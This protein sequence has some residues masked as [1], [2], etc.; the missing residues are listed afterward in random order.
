LIIE[1]RK[2]LGPSPLE[3]REVGSGLLQIADMTDFY[4]ADTTVYL[5]LMSARARLRF[6]DDAAIIP[7]LRDLLW[8]TALRLE[9]GNSGLAEREMRAAQ[10]AVAEAM[11]RKAPQDEIDKLIARLQEAIQRYMEQMLADAPEIDPSE[12]P[13]DAQV[14][15]SQDLQDMLEKL[16]EA[17]KNG[18]M[19]KAQQLM[20]QLQQMLEQMRNARAMRQPNGE[21]GDQQQSEMMRQ[22]QEMARRQREML[23]RTF[24]QQQSRR[25]QRGQQGQQGQQGNQPGQQ[26][27]GELSAEQERIRRQLGEMMRQLAE[28]GG[29]PNQLGRA[30]QAMRDAQGALDRGQPGEAL[31]PEAEALDQ[32]QQAGRAM[33]RGEVRQLG[34]GDPSQL[35]QQGQREQG[36]RDPL[37]RDSSGGMSSDT[38]DVGI[39]GEGETQRARRIWDELQRRAGDR[40]RPSFERDYLDRL[41]KT[42]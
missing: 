1:Q 10:R 13:P 15:S 34:Q 7:E 42:Y 19:D 14:M 22:L 16:R 2:K 20:A 37:G 12:I 33:S 11:A 38:N 8:D 35:Q 28:R 40:A 39:P 26:G 9:D 5:A 27:M 36:Q 18:Q 24:Q 3:R 17:L 30:E 25:G 21:G 23:D 6:N 32:L 29:M 41:L 4:D 31:G